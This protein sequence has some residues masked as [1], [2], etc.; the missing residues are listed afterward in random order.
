MDQIEACL[1]I[2]GQVGS[3]GAWALN[4][5]A[6][7]QWLENCPIEKSWEDRVIKLYGTF[8]P[9]I[10][11]CPPRTNSLRRQNPER[12]NEWREEP[13]KESRSLWLL[14][15][16]MFASYS[17]PQPLLISPPP[18]A[19]DRIPEIPEARERPGEAHVVCA[20]L[21]GFVREAE[22]RVLRAFQGRPFKPRPLLVW[23]LVN[24]QSHWDAAL[25]ASFDQNVDRYFCHRSSSHLAS[26]D[27]QTIMLNEWNIS[28]S[29]F[30][31]WM[32]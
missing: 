4:W 17:T 18:A 30:S 20:A 10:F 22:G 7:A 3:E 16:C 23:R 8:Y 19:I 14:W 31:G 29:F 9:H 24:H 21:G 28:V 5:L 32:K 25:K 15:R 12:E 13:V 6:E 11:L 1:G 2:E 27:G 26:Y